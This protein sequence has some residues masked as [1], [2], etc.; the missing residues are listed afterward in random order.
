MHA[1]SRKIPTL[2]KEDLTE[3][4]LPKHH[5]NISDMKDISS[6][7]VLLDLAQWF[8]HKL[9]E[10]FDGHPIWIPVREL[11]SWIGRFVPLHVKV[12][13]SLEDIKVS[14]VGEPNPFY[15]TDEVRRYARIFSNR[16]TKKQARVLCLGF[17]E[18]LSQAEVAQRL[19]KGSASAVNYHLD[20][21]KEKLFDFTADLR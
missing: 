9:S 2:A 21:I 1:D 3:I 15:D 14:D 13:E 18:Q 12:S 5:S 20:Q 7:A 4:N 16:L 19:G 6:G 17:G 10:T 11:V 8:W